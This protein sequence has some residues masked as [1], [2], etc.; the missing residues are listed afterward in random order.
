MVQH[1]ILI[2]IN[3]VKQLF[4]IVNYINKNNIQKRF[5][6]FFILACDERGNDGILNFEEVSSCYYEMTVASKWLCKLPA[7]RY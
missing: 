4:I 6:L 1:V 2:Q 7:F 5:V 3:H